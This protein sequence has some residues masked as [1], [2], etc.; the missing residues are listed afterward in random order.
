MMRRVRGG[1]IAA[2]ILSWPASP[3]PVPL[4]G[5]AA[6]A[7]EPPA[8]PPPDES[9]GIVRDYEVGDTTTIS[10]RIRSASGNPLP[11]DL[12][13]G[14]S[15]HRVR[16]KRRWSRTIP[17]GPSGTF[18]IDGL[19]KG[20]LHR[21]TV[22]RWNSTIKVTLDRVPCGARDVDITLQQAGTIAGRVL[23]EAGR[24]AGA[25][26]MV[27]ALLTRRGQSGTLP[28]GGYSSAR[29][30]EDGSFLVEYLDA[31][32]FTVTATTGARGAESR[33]YACKIPLGA[34]G[35]VLRF[36]RKDQRDPA[37]PNFSRTSPH[38]P[39]PTAITGRLLLREGSELPEHF[40]LEAVPET[41][42][43][44]KAF[45]PDPD[46]I[47]DTG[48]LPD[49]TWTLRGVSPDGLMAGER[50]GIKAGSREVAIPLDT[51]GW[52]EGRVLAAD[53]TP[54]GA[55]FVVRA[56]VPG[57]SEARGPGRDGTALTRKDGSF[58]VEFLKE[59]RFTL[60]VMP[61]HTED[62]RP[63]PEI[64]ASVQRDVPTGSRW[65]TLRFVVPVTVTGTV[66]NL[67]GK[68]LPGVEVD[69][70]Q[71]DRESGDFAR[72]DRDGTF[73]LRRLAAGKFRVILSRENEKAELGDFEAPADGLVIKYP[74]EFTEPAGKTPPTNR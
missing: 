14:I 19:E 32:D 59:F 44:K 20:A 61:P 57:D 4:F 23:D 22:L 16:G 39:A 60:S 63:H 30:R 2:L 47:F 43:E 13:L 5:P 58:R 1:L 56:S 45:Y 49:G 64:P 71:A 68:P 38:E 10:G 48:T 42:G 9:D 53:G 7:E 8:P 28:A 15:G 74:I 31:T 73:T 55:G 35:G 12:D 67:D 26:V 70:R 17:I 69:A 37:T 18:T 41:G 52:I 50:R 40:K 11:E 6:L 62:P 46:G 65:T 27:S 66:T 36:P 25:G 51:H 72:T 29:T 54:V 33:A 21:I 24:P 3:V 34:T